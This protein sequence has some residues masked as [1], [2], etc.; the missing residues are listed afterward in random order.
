[1]SLFGGDGGILRSSIDCGDVG[2]L[3]S[4]VQMQGCLI[5]NFRLTQ[6]GICSYLIVVNNIC[7]PVAAE[8]VLEF[9][10]LVEPNHSLEGYGQS[11]GLS[12]DY[13]L[14]RLGCFLEQDT[15]VVDQI[16]C[17]VIRLIVRPILRCL[18]SEE[19]LAID[20]QPGL[21]GIDLVVFPYQ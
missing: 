1:M 2:G 7:R 21:L 19:N 18:E 15:L 3:L 10:H 14:P 12:G 11:G 6:G 13:H 5:L 17:T 4:L 8:T 20:V 16:L 9:L